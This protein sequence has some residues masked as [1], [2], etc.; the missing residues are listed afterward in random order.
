MIEYLMSVSMTAPLLAAM[1]SLVAVYIVCLIV[2]GGLLV[3]STFFGGDADADVS[4]DVGADVDVDV[5]ADVDVDLDTAGDTTV[6]AGAVDAH[7]APSVLSLTT[8]FSVQFLIY[9]TAMFGLVGATLSYLS[10]ASSVVVLAWAVLG[11]LVVGQGV[12]QLLRYLRRSSGDSKI[13]RK[14]FVNRLGRVTVAIAPQQRGEVAVRTRGGERFVAARA[15]RADESFKIGDTVGI[16][17]FSGGRAEVVS[18]EE[19]EFVS[20]S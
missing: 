10:G 3:L 18:R 2:G 8:W 1:P 9:F 11:G 4:A 14:D 7:H 17:G 16:V 19:F 20:E 13:T 5:D 6:D 15:R 12:H